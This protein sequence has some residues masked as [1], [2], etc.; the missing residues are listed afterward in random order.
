MWDN[1]LSEETTLQYL[2]IRD[3]NSRRL[4]LDR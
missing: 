2:M 1:G 4:A 3:G